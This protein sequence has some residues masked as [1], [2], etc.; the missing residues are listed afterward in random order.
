VVVEGAGAL[1]GVPVTDAARRTGSENRTR[2]RSA[3]G[4]VDDEAAWIAEI[5]RARDRG[6]PAP[7]AEIVDRYGARVR[8]VLRGLVGSEGDADDVFQE[9]FTK[10]FRSLHRF[11]GKSS[12]FTWIYRIAVNAAH[13]HNKRKRRTRAVPMSAL[14]GPDGEEPE[15]PAAETRRDTERLMALERVD[16]VHRALATLPESFRDILVLRE[17]DGLSYEEIASVLGLKKGTVESRLFRARQALREV[18]ERLHLD[19]LL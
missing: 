7:F 8:A 19:E 18:A 13:D 15:F 14:V 2:E 10:V 4:A 11:G 17:L 9:A 6:D 5:V 16:A 12:L 3:V 1:I